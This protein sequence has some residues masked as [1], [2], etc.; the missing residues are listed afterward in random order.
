MTSNVPWPRSTMSSMNGL[1]LA[2]SS[3]QVA[4]IPRSR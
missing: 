3:T 1:L 2:G 4:W